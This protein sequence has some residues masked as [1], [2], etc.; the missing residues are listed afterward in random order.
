M[1][2]L[3]LIILSFCLSDIVLGQQK[4]TELIASSK[5]NNVTVY[6]IGA[7]IQREANISLSAGRT[8]IKLEGLSASI[9]TASLTAGIKG[10]VKIISITHQINY[11][12]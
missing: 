8:R 10:D 1:R 7:E 6:L 9:N 12:S 3:N 5:I 2:Y 4:D 11:L